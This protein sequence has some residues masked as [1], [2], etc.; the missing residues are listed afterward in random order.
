MSSTSYDGPGK[1]SDKQ[2]HK[3]TSSSSC[4]QRHQS[5]ETPSFIKEL[6]NTKL[7]KGRRGELSV[8][9]TGEPKPTVTW[10]LGK[11]L[12]SETDDVHLHSL[13]DGWE[14]LV[15]DRV[16][17]QHQGLY[18]V[19]AF[20]NTGIK[21]SSTFINVMA[22][23]PVVTSLCEPHIN[24]VSGEDLFIVVSIVTDDAKHHTKWYKNKVV[25]TSKHGVKLENSTAM[26]TLQI[27]L[28]NV[29]NG[30]LYTCEV[31][32]AVGTTD[33]SFHVHIQG[34]Y[35]FS[36]TSIASIRVCSKIT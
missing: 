34:T 15:I 30:G 11:K 32:D 13:Q 31:K 19:S 26:S 35:Y 3:S 16:S 8:Q 5:T 14:K 7:L 33:I 25:L 21:Y 6:Q 20:N 22:P 28:V 2:Y 10:K 17:S 1:Q 24:I 27:K 23:P 29:K 9:V 4:K 36:R 18:K 12:I